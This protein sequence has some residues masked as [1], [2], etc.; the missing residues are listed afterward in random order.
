MKDNT[1]SDSAEALKHHTKYCN[2]TTWIVYLHQTRDKLYSESTNTP[3]LAVNKFHL[4]H[5]TS[6]HMTVTKLSK[7]W[8]GTSKGL[9]NSLMQW[10]SLLRHNK[11]ISWTLKSAEYEN[12]NNTIPW[13]QRV[14]LSTH[15]KFFRCQGTCKWQWTEWMLQ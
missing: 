4:K 9:N 10:N 3:V 13:P 5:D 11:L 15:F 12:L 7:S 14:Q 8:Q 6:Q 2:N 1:R